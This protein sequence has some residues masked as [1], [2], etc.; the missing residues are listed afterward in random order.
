MT[1]QEA[2]REALYCQ[3][4]CNLSGI[5]HSF[6]RVLTEGVWPEAHK[7]GQGT[8]WVNTHPV[9]V[10]FAYKICALSGHEPLGHARYDQAFLWCEEVARGNVKT[11]T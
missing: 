11:F 3:D 1:I 4:A 8:T 6:S 10:L 9:S 2:A 5:V 7:T